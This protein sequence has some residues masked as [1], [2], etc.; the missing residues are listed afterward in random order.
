MLEVSLFAAFIAGLITFLAPC[1]LPLVPGYLG[2]VSGV[3]LKDLEDPAKARHVRSKIFLNGFFFTVGFS[4]I[5]IILGTAI[6]L[7]GGALAQYQVWLN[8]IGGIL[9]VLFGLFML[10]VIKIPALQFEHRLKLPQFIRRGNPTSSFIMGAAFGTGWTPCVGPVLGAILTLSA[11]V[12]G[13][14]QGALLLSVF[15]LGLAIPFWII[16]LGIGSATLYIQKFI[17]YLRVISVIGGLF[18]IFL[19]VLLF[20]G[21]LGLLISWGFQI[22]SLFGLDAYEERLLEFL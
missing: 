14:L 22:M 19:G 2:F 3:P 10:D 12:D 8:R 17:N 16:A 5:F 18:L 20:I 13:A 11:T 9:I 1:T 6:G 4:A 21:K 15:S 7:L